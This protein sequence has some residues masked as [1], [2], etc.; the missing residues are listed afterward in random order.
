MAKTKLEA[1]LRD[2][3]T[4]VKTLKSKVEFLEKERKNLQSQSESQTQ[5]QNSQVKA[6]EAVSFRIVIDWKI[7]LIL[8]CQNVCCFWGIAASD[9]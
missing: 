6:L 3:E 4:E 9:L 8:L 7:I 1:L 5:V 2:L